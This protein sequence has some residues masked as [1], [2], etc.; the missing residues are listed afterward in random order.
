MGLMN[1]ILVGVIGSLVAAEIYCLLPR[2]SRWV[3]TRATKKLPANLRER[4][5]E[6]W[7]SYLNDWDGNIGKFC[8]ALGFV[9]S[10]RQ[11]LAQWHAQR[12]PRNRR[13]VKYAYAFAG[14]MYCNL[15]LARTIP[16]GAS[17]FG[18]YWTA[19][20][21]IMLLPSEDREQVVEYLLQ[22]VAAPFGSS[23]MEKSSAARLR[24]A[25]IVRRA[26]RAW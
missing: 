7:Q 16:F 12:D 23:I 2:I 1:G 4:Y 3:A 15:F 25:R 20:G 18:Y 6:E 22:G 10:S 26:V 13:L 9:W 17:V 19:I 5:S 21:T 8:S 11:L 14:S 24:V